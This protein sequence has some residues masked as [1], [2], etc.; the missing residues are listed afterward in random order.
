MLMARLFWSS[1]G[2]LQKPPNQGSHLTFVWQPRFFRSLKGSGKPHT[3]VPKA[4]CAEAASKSKAVPNVDR[5]SFFRSLFKKDPEVRNEE[6]Q[7]EG[8]SVAVNFT[9][10]GLTA[11]QHSSRVHDDLASAKKE[12]GEKGRMHHKRPN[13]N[14]HKRRFFAKGRQHQEYLNSTRKF[15]SH[16]TCELMTDWFTC[17]VSIT[18]RPSCWHMFAKAQSEWCFARSLTT[19]DKFK[20]LPLSSTQVLSQDLMCSSLAV[21]PASVLV[22]E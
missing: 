1:N 3:Q 11:F 15:S 17:H 12:A 5:K 13:Y 14:C 9:L 7:D 22:I 21:I 10:E 8:V 16:C 6:P 4:T 2:Q 20:S 18:Y 19:A